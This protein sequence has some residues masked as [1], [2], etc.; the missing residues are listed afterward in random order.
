VPPH[1]W[2][3]RQLEALVDERLAERNLV[4]EFYF[5]LSMIVRRYIERRFDLMAPEW[6]TQ[7]FMTRVQLNSR[8]PAEYRPLLGDFLQACDLVKFARHAPQRDEIEA[9]LSTARDFVAR[10]AESESRRAAE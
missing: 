5:R 4:S 3:L 9:T 6:T 8:L 7:E 2:A 10:S 1:E